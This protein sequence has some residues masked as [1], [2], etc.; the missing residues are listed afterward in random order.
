MNEIQKKKFL[1]ENEENIKL[2]LWCARKGMRTFDMRQFIPLKISAIERLRIKVK[3][4][5]IEVPT[6]NGRAPKDY[7]KRIDL[8][9]IPFHKE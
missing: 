7:W 9:E 4:C 5:G 3:K 2:L 6:L 8:T 1:E